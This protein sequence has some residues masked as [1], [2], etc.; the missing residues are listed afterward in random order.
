MKVIIPMAG[1]SRRFKEMG[2]DVPKPFIAIDDKTMIERVCQ[3]FAPTDEF[4]F[5][6]NKEHL[7]VEEHRKILEQA[8]RKCHI[9]E[10][11]PHEYGP[12]H[13]VLQARERITNEN[14]PIIITYCDFTMQWNYR[15]FLL[16]ASLYEGAVVVFRGFHP[17]S[18]GDTYYGY[19]KEDS[20]LEMIGLR[21]K[22]PF[23]DNR[24]DEFAATGVYYFESWKTFYEYANQMISEGE[25][26]SNE[27]HCS[28]ILNY[29]VRD[30]KKVVLFEVD[31]FICWGTPNDLQ[32]YQFWS[33]YFAKDVSRMLLESTTRDYAVRIKDVQLGLKK[34]GPNSEKAK[35]TNL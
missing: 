14:E 30:N 7:V 6:C 4:V 27:Y 20:N 9:V 33:E 18:M 29:L 5:I 12:V 28:L 16:K 1:H 26:V 24:M 11:E 8:V 15:Q 23:T 10:I 35:A 25:K 21:E 3:M 19:I 17:A 34:L 2:Y 32:E 13:S 31:K 22:Q